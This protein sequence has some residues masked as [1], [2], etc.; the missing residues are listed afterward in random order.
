M[1]NILYSLLLLLI[2][3]ICVAG[4]PPVTA[5]VPNHITVGTEVFIGYDDGIFPCLEAFPNFQGLSEYIEMDEN[6]EIEITVSGVA[7]FPCFG[8]PTPIGQFQFFSLGVLPVGDYS[9]QVYWTDP[10][11]PLPVPPNLNRFEIGE[12]VQ[13]QV[14]APIVIPASNLYSLA[15]L[16]LLVFFLALYFIKKNP[17]ILFVSLIFLLFFSQQL[18]AK[19]FHILLSAEDGTP[20]AE[21]VV[22]EALLSAKI[23]KTNLIR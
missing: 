11:T 13:F 14:N 1:K 2:N 16:V 6:N 17:K 9:I 5:I 20:S 4:T 23:V 19:T 15:L 3:H 22:N 7:Q 18:S 8:F 10:A 21:F 12:I